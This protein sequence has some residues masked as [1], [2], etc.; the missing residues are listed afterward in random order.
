M[1]WTAPALAHQLVLAR[2]H[3]SEIVSSA[4]SVS[5]RLIIRSCGP[6]IGSDLLAELER[7]FQQLV[8]AREPVGEPHPVGLGALVDAPA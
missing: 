1:L 5:R 7:A 6:G 3:D 2:L 4:F 8:G